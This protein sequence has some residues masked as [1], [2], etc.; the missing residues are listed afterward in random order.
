MKAKKESKI[1]EIADPKDNKY[2][3]VL[4]ASKRARQLL[5]RAEKHGTAVD[6]EKVILQALHEFWD[7]KVTYEFPE[8]AAPFKKKSKEKD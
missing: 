5:E 7:G 3:M 4:T 6:T 1:I 2:L 8:E